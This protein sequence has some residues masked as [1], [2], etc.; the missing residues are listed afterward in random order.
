MAKTIIVVDGSYSI[1]NV[2]GTKYVGGLVGLDSIYQYRPNTYNLERQV[3]RSYAQGDVKGTLYIGGVLGKSNFGYFNSSSSSYFYSTLDSV[4]HT[5]GIVDGISLVGGVAGYTYGSIT[6]SYS[7]S[8]V[9]GTLDTIGGLAGYVMKKIRNSYSEGSVKGY[10]VVGGLVGYTK[11]SVTA[12][13]SE[14]NVA[15]T[16]SYI[17]GLV[18]YGRSIDLS[19]H[20]DG[21]VNGHAYVG[22]LVGY[23]AYSVTGSHSEGSVTGIENYVGGLVGYGRL[24]GSSYHEGGEVKGV[25]YVGGLAGYTT[26]SVTDSHSEGD[27]TGSGGYVGGLAGYTT[28]SVTGSHS[29]GDITGTS[30]YVGGLI[31]LSY[32]YYS[33]SSDITIMTAQNSYAVGNVKGKGC[34]GGLVGLDSVYRYSNNKNVLVKKISNSHS[35]GMVIG[36]D[37]YVG[38]VLGK[39]NY[40]YRSSSYSSNISLQIHSSYHEGSVVGDSSYVGGV[41]GYARGNID[42]TYHINGAVNGYGYVGGLVGQA[43]S[44]V[45]NSYSEGNVLGSKD[46]VGGVAGSASG[47][48]RNSYA[49]AKHIRGRNIIGG[50]AGYVTDSIDVSYFEGDSVTG[51]NRIGGLV[52]RADKAVDSSYSTANVKGD[53]EVGGLIGSAYGDVSNSYAIGNVVGDVEHSSAGNDNLGGLVGYQYGGSVS[54]SMALGNVSGTTKLGGLV[55]R[56]DGTKISQSYANGNVTGDY[57]GDPADE[58]GNYYIGG[59]VGYAKGSLSETYASGVV[60]GMEDEPVYTGCI[61]GYVNGSLNITKSY[62]DKTKCSLGVDGGEETA[63]VTGSPDKTTTEMQTQSTFVNW[64]FVDTWKI[65]ENTYPFLKIFTNSLTNAVVTTASLE[66]IVYDGS[67]KTPIVTSVE[68]FG[69]TLTYGTDYTVAYKNNVDAGTA[70]INVCGVNPYGGCKVINFV[71]NAVAIVP[72]IASIEDVTYSGVALTP[73]ISVYNGGTLLTDADYIV[74]YADNLNAGTASVSVTLKGNYS[75][76]ASKTFTVE[77]ATPVISQ[78]PT[79][80]NVINGQTLAS[81]ELT[82]GNA[83]VEGSFVW[84]APETVPTLEND[85]YIAVFAPTDT[86]NYDSVETTVPVEVLDYVYVAVHVGDETLDS[87]VVIKGGN[88]TLPN[89]PDSV[90]HDF[91]GLY[92]GNAIVGNPGD[93]IVL[94]ENTVIEAIYEAKTFAIIFANGNVV[95]QSENT[96]YG[97]LPEYRG[98]TPTKTA[99]AQYTYTFKGWNPAIASVTGAATYTAVFD[100]TVK[101]YTVTFMDGVTVLQSGEV[102]YGTVPT[103]PAVTLPENTAQYSYSFGG[104]DSEVV[105]VTGPATYTA[106]INRT[107]NK[108]E[109]VFKDYDGTVLKAAVEYDYGT[110]ADN[111]VKPSDP[112]QESTAQYTYTFKGW[113]PSIADVTEAAI[114]TAEYDS[115]VR[116]YEIAFVNGSSTLQSGAV[117]YGQTPVYTGDIPTK[118]AT[119]QY[120]YTFKGWTPTIASVTGEATYAAVFDNVVN[121]YLITFKNGSEVIQADSIAYGTVPEKPSITLPMNTAQYTYSLSWDKDIVAVTGEATYTATIDSAVNKYDVVFKDYDGTVLKDSIYA[122]G[123][124]ASKI[125]EPA[126]PTRAATAKYT[127]AFKGWS[128]SVADVTTDAAYTA[129]YDSTIRSYTIAF[130]N[131]S[132]TEQ[133]SEVEYGEMPSYKGSTPTKTATKEYTYTFK[134]WSPAVT[135]VSGAA[136]YTAVFDST[137]RKYTVTFMNDDVE[138]QTSSVAYGSTPVYSGK[139][140]T[141]TASDS[142]TY[143][144]SGWSSDLKPVTGDV[145]YTAKFEVVKKTFVVRF[146][147]EKSNYQVMY[148]AYGDTP[149]YTGNTPTKNATNSYTYEFVGWS[150]KLGPVTKETYYTAV[151]DSAKV[152]GIQ[153][154]RL[155]SLN[156]S[157]SAVSRNIKISAAPVGSAYAIFDMQG[158]VLRKGRVESPNFSIMMPQAGTCFVKIGNYVQRI[159]VK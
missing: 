127:F 96:A 135:S 60:K 153:D 16:G 150:P 148:V 38:G 147:Y 63:T 14:G 79:A 17:G 149:K 111:V 21:N 159:D 138:M 5:N 113:N 77:K 140:P 46:Y 65:Y 125:A 91:V 67:A 144:F 35:I 75:G 126:D 64:D 108:Y 106:V 133:S 129:A 120:T 15:G 89:V 119:V 74:E 72:T 52:G 34:V 57:Y 19:Y 30:S 117:E 1:G 95:L 44:S 85:G 37:K 3:K 73:E 157:V 54:K 94:N 124:L 78:N 2:K 31:G 98:E 45:K 87:A 42:S 59:L 28:G 92:K 50:L 116:S 139:T 114:Y 23:T 86:L 41:A 123:T 58:V 82:G 47:K 143:K 53:D 128:P 36:D 84:L 97:T 156:I 112:T 62:Y 26:G 32:Y 99:T 66:N 141:K 9:V 83:D 158:R 24:I 110:S 8:D 90:G 146:V 12:S 152:T 155:A 4:S 105:A 51:I 104:W 27:V 22:G 100:S 102:A 18:G 130:V 137:I 115:T 121:R 29:E 70:T 56:F 101:K 80:S 43:T 142:C 76:S 68:L 69:E 39:S 118:T 20:K 7:K 109:V 11:D 136:T 134:G 151:F 55:G 154:V 71:I 6:N 103:A 131:G 93:V 122:Y 13:H 10:N 107:L 88:Y 49:V 132:E 48:I 61:V 145:I 40:G 81:S 25:S 33:G